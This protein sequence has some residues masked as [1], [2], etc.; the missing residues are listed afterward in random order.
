MDS[1]DAA[2]IRIAGGTDEI[3]KNI[4]S[5]QVLGMP[6]DMRADKGF[7]STKYLQVISNSEDNLKAQTHFLN[8]EFAPFSLKIILI[9]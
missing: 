3:L 4:I 6:Q 1:T 2:G 5:E 8:S 9:F 7:L